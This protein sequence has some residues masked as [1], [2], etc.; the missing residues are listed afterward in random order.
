MLVRGD[1]V[2]APKPNI[3][4]EEKVPRHKISSSYREPKWP[5]PRLKNRETKGKKKNLR[6]A[7]DVAPEVPPTQRRSRRLD[8]SSSKKEE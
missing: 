5:S 4:T 6:G 7:L 8:G 2:Q 3:T 1:Y